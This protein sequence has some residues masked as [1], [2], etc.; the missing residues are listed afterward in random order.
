MSDY[1]LRPIS[2]DLSVEKRRI[3]SIVAKQRRLAKSAQQTCTVG[4][5][6]LIGQ[7]GADGHLA[8]NLAFSVSL[9]QFLLL[10]LKDWP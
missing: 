3:Q 10:P 2:R 7:A 5:E 8:G 4:R 9:R 6:V 1:S